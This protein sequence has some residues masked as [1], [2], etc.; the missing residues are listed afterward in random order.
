LLS[1]FQR[2]EIVQVRRAASDRVTAGDHAEIRWT[3]ALLDALMRGDSPPAA[4]THPMS[5]LP[6]G[7][8]TEAALVACGREQT[9]IHILV[10]AEVSFR[11]PVPRDRDWTARA[12][13]EGFGGRHV[14]VG[15]VLLADG[16][17]LCRATLGVAR[18]VDGHASPVLASGACLPAVDG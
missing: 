9:G 15:A 18:V 17:E 14:R 12:S 5:G 11:A 3:P 16:R 4:G 8:M 10:F 1:S 13:V 6:L 2:P 7:V